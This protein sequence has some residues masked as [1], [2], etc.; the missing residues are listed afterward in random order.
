M[1]KPV[2]SRYPVDWKHE[3]TV[4]LNWKSDEMNFPNDEVM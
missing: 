3:S 4:V 2:M 1:V